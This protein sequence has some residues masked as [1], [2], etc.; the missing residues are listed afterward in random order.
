MFRDFSEESKQNILTMVNEVEN[1]NICMIK[2]WV[3]DRWYD[4]E[5]WITKLGVGNYVDNVNGYN[6]KV[7]DKN[8]ATKRSIEE[9]FQRVSYVNSTY[10]SV[11]SNLLE[12][13]D[14]IDKYLNTMN[15]IV[16]P[17]KGN[18]TSACISGS[19]DPVA[20]EIVAANVLCLRD[21]LVQKI[22][23]RTFFNEEVI[24]EY[25]EMD[26]EDLS[27]EEKEVLRE[28][29]AELS[30]TVLKYE[31]L[32]VNMEY[33][34]ADDSDISL[35]LYNVDHDDFLEEV[36]EQK[37]AYNTVMNCIMEQ[38]KAGSVFAKELVIEHGNELK[39]R[40][41]IDNLFDFWLNRSG[42]YDNYKVKESVKGSWKNTEGNE[43]IKDN[44][45]EK[46]NYKET[47]IPAKYYDIKKGKGIS[48]EDAPKYYS[49]EDTIAEYKKGA[50]YSN[51][52]KEKSIG[53]VT[54][55]MGHSE[56]DGTFRAG[57]YTYEN[58]DNKFINPGFNF[59][60]S[61]SVSGLEINAPWQICGNEMLGLNSNVNIKV[62]TAGYDSNIGVQIFDD[63]HKPDVQVGV[64][65]GAEA[66]VAEAKGEAGVNILGGNHKISGSVGFGAKAHGA[67]AIQDG[68]L[69]YD[70]GLGL[71][72]VLSTSGEIDIVGTVSTVYGEAKCAIELVEDE[73][74]KF[75]D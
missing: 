69:K 11:F 42:E 26:P 10:T 15:D 57:L 50:S 36:S 49:E 37:S 17:G 1:E 32:N 31:K 44:L 24:C 61:G 4:F 72:L 39:S 13:L 65:L 34:G 7:I 53:N 14:N 60:S 52:W 68:V 51:S 45:K 12:S 23:E 6:K 70:Y 41:I 22:G 29:I 18:F 38:S 71:G 62:L 9:I 67:F 8:N 40:I 30:G 5:E 75:F 47:D 16:T 58:D 21:S 66:M 74:E 64:D 55:D 25:L 43:K 28:V 20:N 33:K 27:D 59:S 73:Y 46:G 54:I 2:D 48:E 35:V 3:G 63:N 19:L 56:V